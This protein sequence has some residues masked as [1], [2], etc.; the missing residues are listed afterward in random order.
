LFGD[1]QRISNVSYYGMARN[2]E[3]LDQFCDA[4]SAVDAWVSIKPQND[5]SQAQAMISTYRNKA[6]CE[7]ATAT[8]EEVFPVPRAGNIVKLPVSI[9]GTRGFFILDTGATFVSLKNTFAQKVKAQVDP[10]ST[11]QMHTANG[12]VTAKRGRVQTIQLRSLQAKDVPVVVQDN[13]K[14]AFGDDVDGLL[15]MSF[16]SRFKLTVDARTVTIS[17]RK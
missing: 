3:K 8:S 13:A 4:I 10:D 6:K 11:V 16:L 9:N 7:L 12:I 2:Y 17:G 1:K 14:A 15:G 5:T